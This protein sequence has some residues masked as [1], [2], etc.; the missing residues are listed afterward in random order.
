[1]IG[2]PV[3]LVDDSA[4]HRKLLEQTLSQESCSIHVAKNGSEAMEIFASE[5]PAIVITDYLMPDLTGVELCRQ[6]RAVQASYTYIIMVTSITEKENVVEGLAAGADDYLTKPFHR[7]ELLARVRVGWRLIDLQRQLEAKNRLLEELALT[8]ALTGLPNRR[9]VEGW[10]EHQLHAAAR[11]GF[12]F[13][14]VL[15]DLDN[16]KRVNDTYGHD[17][18]DA[19]LKEFA[20]ILKSHTR[21][22][23]ISGRIGGEEFLHVLTH[24]D[25]AAVRI[26]A[27]RI[28]AQF[29]A[30]SFSFGGANVTVTAS[31]GAV[32]FRGNTAPAFGNLVSRADTALY[33]AKR[34][35][36]NRIEVEPLHRS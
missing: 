14:V 23:N 6:I 11:Y 36:R 20:D 9:A 12:P 19:V 2:F 33:R 34:Q 24:A 22:S 21:S 17:A 3:M 15:I 28:R 8:D 5:H 16:F 35:G 13:W 32:G 4:V 26:V 10:A 7:E 30:Q 27:E 1:M 18:G 29:A 31:F 25:E